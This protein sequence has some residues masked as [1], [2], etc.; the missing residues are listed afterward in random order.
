MS[1]HLKTA[2]EQSLR[3]AQAMMADAK[4]GQTELEWLEQKKA[5]HRRAFRVPFDFLDKFWPPENTVEYWKMV[6]DRMALLDGENRENELCRKFL[7]AVTEYLE[8]VG[9]ERD[10]R[11]DV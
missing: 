9:K 3:A 5:L 2:Y 10:K 8:D 6:T 7:V 4:K 11:G 1:E